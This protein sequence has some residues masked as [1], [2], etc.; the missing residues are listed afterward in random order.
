MNVKLKAIYRG[1]K[2]VPR[3]AFDLPEESEVN[4]TVEGPN[5][6]PPQVSDCAERARVVRN[7][8]ERMRKNPIPENAPRLTR[9]ELHERR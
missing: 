9:D 8:T 5:T 3:E 6:I 2:F 7:V 1:G 4:L